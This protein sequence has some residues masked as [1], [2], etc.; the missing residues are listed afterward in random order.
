MTTTITIL[1][2]GSSGGVP[3]IANEWGQCDPHNRKNRRLRCSIL[4]TKQA[5]NGG[6]TNVLI[7]TSPDLRQQLNAANTGVLDAV[8]YTHPHADHI[9]GID[10]LR[11]IT[12]KTCKRVTVYADE[13]TAEK[14][15]SRFDYCFKTP[16]NSDYPPILNLKQLQ[17]GQPVT[18]TGEGGDIT[19]TPF[20]VHHGRID[21][22]GF[23]IK[24]TAYTPDLNGIPAESLPVIENLDCWIVDALRRTPH[25]SHFSLPETLTWI[26]KIAPAKALL[27][28]LH[29]DM[30]Y[31]TTGRNTPDNVQVCYDGH[32]FTI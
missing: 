29:T 19:A 25:P 32:T 11:P 16:P 10:D 30:D 13:P 15:I 12:I 5:A 24:N 18:I 20:L 9:H 23:R 3:R 21:A 31:E 28:N 1:G 4:I 7:D 27:T 8:L 26:E 6:R 22:L 17:H 14:L 2:C